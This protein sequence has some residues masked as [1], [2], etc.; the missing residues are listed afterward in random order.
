MISELTLYKRSAT[1]WQWKDEANNRTVGP[2]HTTEQEAVDW[3]NATLRADI[4]SDKAN[5]QLLPYFE[6]EQQSI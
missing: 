4:G 6:R 2:V 3:V 5:E 1:E